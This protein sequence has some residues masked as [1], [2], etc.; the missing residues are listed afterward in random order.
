[1]LNLEK[2]KHYLLA[3]SFGPDSMALFDMLI[4]EGYRFTVAHVNYHLR[5]ESDEEESLLR[6]YCFNHNIGIYVKDVDED[7]GESNLEMKCRD[8]RYNFFIDVI[9]TNGFDALLVA[10]QEDDLIETYLMQKRRKNLVNYFGIREISYFSNVEIIRPLLKYRKGELMMYCKMFNVPYAIDKTNLEDHFLRNQIRH[11]VV[12]QLSNEERKNIL[13]EIENENKE[14]AKILD[15]VANIKSNK[16]EEY[17]R[18]NDIE[19]LYAIVA[20]GRKIKDDF[21]VSKEQ[22][23]ELRKVMNSDKANVSLIVD[24]LRFLKEYDSISIQEDIEQTD[25]EYVMN[26]PSVL[27]TEYFF[28]DFTKDSSDRNVSLSDYP[29]TI[30]NAKNDDVIEILDFKKDL[31]RMFIDWKMPISFRN[32]W[33]VILNKDGKIIYVPR[34]LKDFVIPPNANFYIKFH[35]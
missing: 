21:I 35:D 30:R 7:L 2:N 13:L 10:H 24:G 11:S 19:F 32:R 29:I 25:F 22:G 12:E 16:I 31:R 4:K 9:K 15:V 8:I 34:Y 20:L 23:A 28:I 1:M 27:D 5:K 17:N 26:E 3:C 18:L 33:P 14:L 6:D